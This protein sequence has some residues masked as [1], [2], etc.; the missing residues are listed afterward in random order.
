MA[1]AEPPAEARLVP[2]NRIGQAINP[3]RVAR[4]PY[5]NAISMNTTRPCHFAGKSFGSGTSRNPSAR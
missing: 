4:R 2:L 3:G 1:G 5:P